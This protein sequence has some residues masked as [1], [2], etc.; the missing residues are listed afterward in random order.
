MKSPFLE[1]FEK[2]FAHLYGPGSERTIK[3][4][5]TPNT[6]LWGAKCSCGWEMEPNEHSVMKQ[7]RRLHAAVHQQKGVRVRIA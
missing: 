6:F 7:Y 1:A 4:W 5:I 3:C 2:K